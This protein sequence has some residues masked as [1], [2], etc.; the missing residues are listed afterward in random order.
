MYTREIQAPVDTPVKDGRPV[1]GTWIRPFSKV[2]LLAI[3]KPFPVPFPR[4]MRDFRIKEWQ[5]FIIQNDEIYF[6]TFV[7]N[8]KFFRFIETIFLDKKTDGG[9]VRYFDF[10]PL[11]FWNIPASLWDSAVTCRAPG[12]FITIHDW[13]D[14]ATIKLDINI[15]STGGNPSINGLFE[16]YANSK[17]NT[18][19]AVNMLFSEERC[20]YTYKTLCPVR[21]NLKFGEHKDFFFRRENTSGV[22]RDCKGIFPYITNNSWATGFGFDKNKRLVGF[23]LGEGAARG[24]NKDN[25]NAL[26]VDGALTPLPPVRITQSGDLKEDW[27]IEDVEGMVDLTFTPAAQ[28]DVSGFNLIVSKAEL[29]SPVGL[30]TGFIMNKDGEKIS[31]EKLSGCAERLYLRL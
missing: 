18:P 20:V 15:E 4:W 8:L 21:G 10:F 19:L 11:S 16:F 27:I 30:F 25:E 23:S 12:Y 26:W 3:E 24:A 13:L 5:S 17:T 31:I 29:V 6:S 28:T 14:A 7:A 9:P 2:D 22:F 1:A